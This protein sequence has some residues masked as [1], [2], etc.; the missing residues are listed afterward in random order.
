M[1]LCPIGG[2]LVRLSVAVRSIR[3]PKIFLTGVAE[4]DGSDRR[5][6]RTARVGG[7]KILRIKTYATKHSFAGQEYA[8]C[9]ILVGAGVTVG[10]G[11]RM[12]RIS[13]IHG[14]SDS[15][16]EFRPSVAG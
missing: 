11:G 4:S 1:G 3:T 5:K 16:F 13:P 7:R 8:A 14:R 6:K 2:G 15:Q 9:S 12:K 10:R